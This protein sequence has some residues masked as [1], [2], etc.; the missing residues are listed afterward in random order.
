MRSKFA[1]AESR[2]IMYSEDQNLSFIKLSSKTV[3]EIATE[4]LDKIAKYRFR[5]RQE[6]IEIRRQEISKTW[7]HRFWK[8][9]IPTDEQ[10]LDYIKHDVFNELYFISIAGAKAEIVAEKLL[11]ACLLSEEI[12]LTVE[13]LDCIS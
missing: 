6:Y 8:K 5:R 11:K 12:Y 4:K 9:P 13:D 10:V 1:D 3:K 7:W 2:L